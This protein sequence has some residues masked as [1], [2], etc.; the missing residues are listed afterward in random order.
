MPVCTAKMQKQW[1]LCFLI[2]P[3]HKTDQINLTAS[4]LEKISVAHRL[5]TFKIKGTIIEDFS[6]PGPNVPYVL[7]VPLPP[8]WGPKDQ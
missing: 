6:R 5:C 1:I 7:P 3:R 2:I 4:N 8:P